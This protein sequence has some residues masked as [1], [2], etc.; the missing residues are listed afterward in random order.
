[1]KI[2]HLSDTHNRHNQLGEL[3]EADIIIHS[4]DFAYAGTE[5][6]VL[7]FIEWFC[8][9]PY[10]YKI[11]IAGNHDDYLFG[12]NIEGL[13]DNCYYLCYS[14]VTIGDIHFYGVPMFLND[15]LSGDYDKHLNNIPND[16]DVLI[17]HQ[18]PLGILDFSENINYGDF[19]LLQN[20]LRIKPKYHLFGHIHAAY[21]IKKNDETLFVNSSI[22]DNNYEIKNKPVIFY[23]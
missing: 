1:M 8:A 11:F 16:T 7:D 10:K 23:L 21:G 12:A 18:P 2:L 3:P 15:V 22:L 17:T 13:P 5:N 6:E 4:G 14:G 20:V 19:I 9:L